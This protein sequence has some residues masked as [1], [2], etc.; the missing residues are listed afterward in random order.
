MLG[1][2]FL[3]DEC[4]RC[5]LFGQADRGARGTTGRRAHAS[6]TIVTHEADPVIGVKVPTCRSSSARTWHRCQRRAQGAAARKPRNIDAGATITVMVLNQSLMRSAGG[7][8]ALGL[9]LR[10]SAAA[11]AGSRR[12]ARP[13]GT[14]V[15]MPAA[16]CRRDG[17]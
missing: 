2:V 4:I 10:R 12:H 5:P 9:P 8:A 1:W 17:A 6:A 3:S 16:Q 13:P 11:A 14:S 7:A 15:E